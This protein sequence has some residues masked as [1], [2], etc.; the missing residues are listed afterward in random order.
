MPEML[1]HLLMVYVNCASS[2]EARTIGETV[3]NLR[4]SPSYD[5]IPQTYSAAFWPPRSGE[6]ERVYGA[7]LLIKTI[8]K[9]YDLVEAEITKLHSDKT[10]GIY[11]I[12]VSRVSETYYNWFISELL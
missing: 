9:N 3:L 6:I 1:T 12:P 10:P 8:D 5:I 7:T 11:A 4:L 2:D